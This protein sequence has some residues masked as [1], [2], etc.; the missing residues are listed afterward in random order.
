MVDVHLL[1]E[2]GCDLRR[3]QHALVCAARRA[4]FLSGKPPAPFAMDTFLPYMRDM[5]R[6][7]QS[8]HELNLM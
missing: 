5:M 8:L 7:E 6:C 2:A 3:F 4:R 1:A